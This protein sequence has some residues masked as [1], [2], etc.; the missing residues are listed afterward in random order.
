MRKPAIILLAILVIVLSAACRSN[1]SETQIAAES[2][3]ERDMKIT[4][5]VNGHDLTATLEDNTSSRALVELLE[6]GEEC[7]LEEII[8][9]VIERDRRDMTRE[10]SPLRQADDAVLVD[11]SYMSIEEVCS[12]ILDL[13]KD[14]KKTALR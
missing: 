10:E 14:K 6:K 11:S 4:I 8:R 9:D 2:E 7:D 5:S 1:T 3:G 13:V 12:A